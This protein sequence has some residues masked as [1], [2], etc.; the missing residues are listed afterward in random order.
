MA[1]KLIMALG[2]IL[3][4]SYSGYAQEYKL[5]SSEKKCVQV[6]QHFAQYLKEDIESKKIPTDSSSIKYL[7]LNYI[8]IDRKLDSTNESKLEQSIF[9]K[10]EYKVLKDELFSFYI[11]FQ[12]RSNV[13]LI[14][15]LILIPLRLAEDTCI[16]NRMTQFQKANTYVLFDKKYMEKPL[17]YILFFPPIKGYT[18]EPRIWSW[19]LGY[20]YGKFYFTAPNGESGYEHIFP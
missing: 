11:Y 17:F 1:R 16:Y 14:E 4:F 7:L 5:D 19:K 3:I 18:N 6:F 2:C 13:N 15:N 20:E 8:F 12:S 10:D 9:L